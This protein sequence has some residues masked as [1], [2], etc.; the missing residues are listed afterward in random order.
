MLAQLAPDVVGP[1][2]ITIAPQPGFQ[3]PFLANR[4][5]IVIGG[6]A[7]GCGKSY[8]EVLAPLPY[9]DIPGFYSVMFRR[10]TVDLRLPNG[11]W[12]ESRKLYPLLRA[13][14]NAS[15][16]EWHFPAGARV[17]MAHLEHE[18]TVLN[19]HGSQLPQVIFDELTTFTAK[20]FWYMVSRLR[21]TC[22]VRPHVL[23]SCNP[24]PDSWVADLIAW[25]IDQ[26]DNSPT[27]GLPIPERAGVI[28]YFARVGDDIVWGD[29]PGEVVADK[30]VEKSVR[31][32]QDVT[33][34]TWDEC[35]HLV[36]KSLSFVPGKLEHNP[37]LEGKDPTY[38]ASLMALGRVE[39][40]RLLEG[41]WKVRA[42]AGDYFK[43]SEVTMLD[44]PPSDVVRTVRRWDLAATEPSVKNADPD[45]TYG[46]KMGV[47]ENG[48]YV[49]LHAIGMQKRVDEVR[50]TIRALAEA[51]GDECAVGVPQDPGQAGVDQLSQYVKLLAGFT[52][53]G[54]REATSKEMRASSFAAQWQAGN[55]D[56]VRGDWNRHFFSQL[57]AFP[58]KGVHDDA[59]DAASG[60]FKRLAQG[61]SIFD[62]M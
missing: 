34:K 21:S 16:L 51:D 13:R 47:R 6:G 50:R 60:A 14:P 1:E 30:S 4:A 3:E 11:L 26:D 19:W 61:V 53:W 35:V 58:T 20:Q 62:L 55:V 28:R 57:E 18:N 37:A 43:R 44:G 15:R 24:D 56:V 52:C 59:V 22:G 9:V 27:F 8:G 10:T 54:D 25:W 33:K 36:V 39:R 48:R 45:W 12:D 49:V 7:A 5:D 31:R 17:R 23:A 46:V 42:Y 29:D 40:E 32:F 38:R 41:N 2:I